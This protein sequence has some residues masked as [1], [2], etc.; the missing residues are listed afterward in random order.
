MKLILGPLMGIV[1]TVP[2]TGLVAGSNHWFQEFSADSARVN[3]YLPLTSQP[4]SS[5]PAHG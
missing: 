5:R 3:N 2:V 4:L 1:S